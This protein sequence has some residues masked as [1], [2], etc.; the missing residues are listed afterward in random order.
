MREVEDTMEDDDSLKHELLAIGR[1][2]TTKAKSE[3]VMEEVPLELEPI[4]SKMLEDLTKRYHTVPQRAY[5]LQLLEDSGREDTEENIRFIDNVY[6]DISTV[7]MTSIQKEAM[8]DKFLLSVFSTYVGKAIE[9]LG[10]DDKKIGDAPKAAL[11]FQS[12][13]KEIIEGFIQPIVTEWRAYHPLAT[14]ADTAV[15]FITMITG[16][17]PGDA[18]R[19]F[20]V[21]RQ[22]ARERAE[23]IMNGLRTGKSEEEVECIN[24]NYDL[25]FELEKPA[26]IISELS[27]S[28]VLF[29]A[30]R[31]HRKLADILA[32]V[33]QGI[34][35]STP[36]V[37]IKKMGEKLVR[38]K[39]IP[40]PKETQ[41]VIVEEPAKALDVL[42]KG[43]YDKTKRTTIV[44]DSNTF[45]EVVEGELEKDLEKA[46]K[47]LEELALGDTGSE[48]K[49]TED[50]E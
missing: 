24:D 11:E 7:E 33:R 50:N 43:V 49:K 12:N 20:I 26:S 47:K 35:T 25:I 39:G 44:S 21:E 10:L 37:K 8:W 15:F 6:G 45:A 14:T 13:T 5:I 42:A 16:L 19:L 34:A 4:P 22:R 29:E 41:E 38:M 30:F 48:E 17:T 1:I 31:E 23:A 27:I 2:S 28:H 9:L 18:S 46:L 40:A 36:V 3:S 32:P